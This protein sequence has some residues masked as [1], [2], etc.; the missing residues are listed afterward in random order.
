MNISGSSPLNLYGV[1]TNAGTVNWGGTGNLAVYNGAY[2][3]TGG[4]V[5]LAGALFNVQN[6]QTIQVTDYNGAVAY[7][8]N[9]GTFLKSAGTNTTINVAFNNAGLVNMESG[10][11]RLLGGFSNATSSS[12]NFVIGGRTAGTNYGQL[13]IA[14]NFP[15][16][17]ALNVC[18]TNGFIPSVGDTFRII[19]WGSKQ[20][21]FSAANGFDLG[22]G[23]Y[24]QG[25]ADRS[26]LTLVTKTTIVPT[27]PPPTNLVDRVVA[28]GDTAVFSFS[29]L[30]VAPFTYQWMF[31]GTN[32]IG[33]TNA[34]LVII[35]VQAGNL[36]NYCVLVT[37]ALGVANTYCAML[38][39]INAAGI[40]TQ[41]SG[42]NA[43]HGHQPHA[44]GSGQW[45]RDAALPM[46]DQR[47]EHSRRNQL[48]LCHRQC[49]TDGWRHLQRAGGQPGPRH[50]QQ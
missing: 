5:N 15:L 17:G 3:Y 20:G 10:T 29:P 19:N 43:A 16:G 6:D 13:L 46:A 9:A 50:F 35:N 33:Q 36:G 21:G 32:L 11:L 30:G 23:L 34:V 28:F 45:R 26:G 2:G 8:N 42:Q 44:Y 38:N 37:D 48:H 24:F 7:F 22:G 49:S 39:A 27:P 12:F 47:R 14:G 18:L 25:I 31:N 41:P 1:L 40:T 4:I